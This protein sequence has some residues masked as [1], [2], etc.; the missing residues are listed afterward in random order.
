[1]IE[2][3]E[4]VIC[5]VEVYVTWWSSLNAP[6]LGLGRRELRGENYS[7]F[8]STLVNL[9]RVFKFGGILRRRASLEAKILN[10]PTLN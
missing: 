4:F 1:V 7:A 8:T 9:A 10:P 5:L 3:E 6:N 2:M